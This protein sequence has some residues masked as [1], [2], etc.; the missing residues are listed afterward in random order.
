MRRVGRRGPPPRPGI[1]L[2]LA[3]SPQGRGDR[4]PPRGMDSRLIGN[5]GVR[6]VGMMGVGG[7][8]VMSMPDSRPAYM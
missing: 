6:G 4:M 8:S 7:Y 5:A 2:T 1:T 3:L